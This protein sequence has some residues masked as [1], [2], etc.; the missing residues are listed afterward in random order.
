MSNSGDLADPRVPW[1]SVGTCCCPETRAGMAAV[2]PIQG[3]APSCCP[4]A[5]TRPDSG[6]LPDSGSCVSGEVEGFTTLKTL[7]FL[8]SFWREGVEGV[9]MGNKAFQNRLLA[10]RGK[11]KDR[12][13]IAY[14]GSSLGNVRGLMQ[15]LRVSCFICGLHFYLLS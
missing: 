11:F 2:T 10:H 3:H 14:S 4:H 12:V 8:S 5:P 7:L 9:Y 13:I 15:H 6:G 1:V